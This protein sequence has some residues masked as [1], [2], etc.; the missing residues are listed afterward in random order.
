[1]ASGKGGGESVTRKKYLYR[2][3]GE[4]VAGEAEETYQSADMARG[5]VMEAA[6]REHYAFLNEADPELVGFITNGPK[7]CSPDAL[8]GDDGLLEIKTA[9]PSVQVERLLRNDLPPEHKAQC[10]GALWVCERDYLDFVSYWPKMPVL[11]VR[12]C[13]DEA[14]IAGLAAAVDD[15][16]AELAQL[17][18]RIRNYGQGQEGANNALLLAG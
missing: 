17:V 5:K 14:Y 4:I 6:A 3:A 1:M 18:A 16:N 9:K 10:Q 12:V 2:L 11:I 15:F 7:G 13:R 8:I